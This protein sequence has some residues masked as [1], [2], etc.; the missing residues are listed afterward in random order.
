[1]LS[2]AATLLA[3]VLDIYTKLVPTSLP[4][5]SC[6]IKIRKLLTSFSLEQKFLVYHRQHDFVIL[7]ICW[8]IIVWLDIDSISYTIVT[9]KL[10]QAKR[11][12]AFFGRIILLVLP[13]VSQWMILQSST[14]T[15]ET[16][17]RTF[18]DVM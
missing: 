18:N 16:T 3:R 7:F 14:I 6:S 8:S 13:S 2:H 12:L 11:R 4:I 5:S 15:V 9:L 17:A 10:E 1:M